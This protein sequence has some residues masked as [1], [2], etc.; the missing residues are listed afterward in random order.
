MEPAQGI[1]TTAQQNAHREGA[2]GTIPMDF[3]A[4]QDIGE[5]LNIGTGTI[6]IDLA[7]S[8]SSQFTFGLGVDVETAFG[9]RQS[10]NTKRVGEVTL[11]EE[12]QEE[13]ELKSSSSPE[14][15]GDT[16]FE[17]DILYYSEDPPC[18]LEPGEVVLEIRG[19]AVRSEV[20]LEKRIIRWKW[21][22]ATQMVGRREQ[23]ALHRECLLD[24]Y[25]VYVSR[26]HFRLDRTVTEKGEIMVT[27]LAINPMYIKRREED[28]HARTEAGMRVHARM[29]YEGG[30]GLDGE[31][32]P[33]NE[34][35]HVNDGD[36]LQLFT[37]QAPLSEWLYWKLWIEG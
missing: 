6:P 30:N 17:A 33:L 35:I 32:I 14:D 24:S 1:P 29:D 28:D 3:A 23:L 16:L 18:E 8:P 7:C 10:A 13:E 34:P 22:Q 11:L 19:R 27:A 2:T 9:A 37:G 25:Q 15:G 12:L 5:Q 4:T 20:P 21:G 36:E 31:Q 26:E